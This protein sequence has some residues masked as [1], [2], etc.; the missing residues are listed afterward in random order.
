MKRISVKD[1]YKAF[2]EEE[3]LLKLEPKHLG[4]GL[5]RNLIA[6]GAKT[7]VLENDYIDIDYSSTYYLQLARSFTPISR[8]TLRAHFFSAQ[9]DETSLE[10]LSPDKFGRLNE[11]YL[12]YAVIRPGKPATLGRTFIRPPKEVGSRLAFF[13]TKA[14]FDADLAGIRLSVD[15]CPYITQDR[16]G[17]ACATASLW[18]ACTPLSRKLPGVAE[19][20][21]V[22]ITSLA[23][24]LDRP[25]GPG[26]V[27]LGLTTEQVARAVAAMG[28]DPRTWEYPD[29]SHLIEACYTSIESGVPPL[30]MV[31]FPR[32]PAQYVGGYQI[33]GFHALAAVGHSIDSTL[34]SSER[35]L[36]DYK[37]MYLSAEFVPSLVI[38]D[39]QNGMYMFAEFS[40]PTANGKALAGLMLHVGDD[41]IR[42]NCIGVFVPMPKRAVMPG[43]TAIRRAAF[44]LQVARREGWIEDKPM[45]LRGY[46]VRSNRLKQSLWTRPS[47]NPVLKRAY[48]ELPMPR[49]V[50]IVEFACMEDW[51]TK[52][53][54]GLRISGE[55]I[56]DSTSPSE[57]RFEFLALHLPGMVTAY[58]AEGNATKRE[59]L[60]LKP[61]EKYPPMQLDKMP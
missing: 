21:S 41:V 23:L 12:G 17:M 36:P 13:P 52:N 9:F 24:S 33:A 29:K 11:D 60:D 22:E 56:L 47:M 27:E 37:D 20:T 10:S 30:V 46:L 7:V 15:A 1:F 53:V 4:E 8:N 50:W 14:S 5:Y 2:S 25:F 57:D 42:A 31:E 19:H 6:L 38:H 51:T 49:Y 54:D 59:T 18:M 26:F 28:Y 32:D 35:L 61:D 55:M 44:W 39:D 16:V 43:H 34:S 58:S 48:R 45:V 40:E 3:R